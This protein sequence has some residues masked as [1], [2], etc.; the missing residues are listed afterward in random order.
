MHHEHRL[1]IQIEK[2]QEQWDL[3]NEKL[4]TIEREE[5][6]AVNREEK[7]SLGKQISE[8]KAELQGIEEQLA[9]LEGRSFPVEGT[10][11]KYKY[12]VASREQETFYELFPPTDDFFEQTDDFNEVDV[13]IFDLEHP[14][15]N[16]LKY[17]GGDTP[18]LDTTFFV[19]STQFETIQN[20]VLNGKNIWDTVKI[21]YS[22]P[23]QILHTQQ[24]L[25]NALSRIKYILE[26]RKEKRKGHEMV[27][28]QTTAQLTLA[29]ARKRER[30][31]PGVYKRT[32]EKEIL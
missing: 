8:T 16:W 1:L 25:A 11:R 28:N 2:L 26:K 19:A 14:P 10:T 22:F 4:T 6:L 3:L 21:C 20:T 15:S 31:N 17:L 29:K 7:F 24:D 32:I 12:Y 27:E 18:N 30:S 23:P 13:I 9:A 5:I